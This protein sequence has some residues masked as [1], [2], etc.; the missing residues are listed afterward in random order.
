LGLSLGSSSFLW[1][2][3]GFYA[4]D[5]K[6][7]P[8]PEN[9]VGFRMLSSIYVGALFGI[10]TILLAIYPINKRLTI[11]IS[12]ELAERRRTSLSQNPLPGNL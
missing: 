11:Q 1:I 8:T 12:D 3:A 9:L 2:M 4:Y 10:C 7:A 5:T 6:V